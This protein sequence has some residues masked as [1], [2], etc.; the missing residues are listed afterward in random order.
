MILR[1][2]IP[3][4]FVVHRKFKP[5]RCT[6]T[7]C[8]DIPN[9]PGIATQTC[10]RTSFDL[11]ACQ[12]PSRQ[13]LSL[14]SQIRKEWKTG[15]DHET[16]TTHALHQKHGRIVRL[17]P[18]VMSVSFSDRVRLAVVSGFETHHR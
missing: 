13:S 4:G 8:G 6:H 17:R 10:Y 3:S 7:F 1:K 9:L 15:R 14:V 12:E 11:I 16:R 5:G 2:D 18:N